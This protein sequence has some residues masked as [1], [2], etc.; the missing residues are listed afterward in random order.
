VVVKPGQSATQA[1]LREHLAPK[2]AKF[3]LP[4]AFAF[5][6][7]IPRSSTGKMLK[8][9]LREQFRDYKPQ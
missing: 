4:D 3:W 1:E 5:V 8:T 7:A 6:D 2:F 9:S